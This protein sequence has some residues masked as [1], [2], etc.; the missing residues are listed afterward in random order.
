[1]R[2]LWF[3]KDSPHLTSAYSKIADELVLKRLS[4]HHH[5]AL[6]CT[7]GYDFGC[8]EFGD[9][10]AYPK[11]QD[12][13]GE[14][15]VLDHYRDFG[16][17]LLVTATDVWIFS[18]L[19]QLAQ[20]GQ[21]LWS[22]WCFIDYPVTQQ[23]KA[24][25]SP[26][27]KVVP[28]SRWLEGQLRGIGLENVSDPIFLGVDHE[29]FKP[30]VGDIDSEGKEITKGRLK[31]GLGFPEDSFAILIVAMNQTY[32]K[33]FEEQFHG[34]Q[35]F[36]ENNPDINV[37][38]YCHSIPRVR[39]GFSL[40]ELALEYDLD[41]QRGDITFADTYTIIC[42]GVL[43]YSEDRMAKIY[44]ACDVL[45]ETTTGASP[46]MP[47]LEAQST[48]LPIITTDYCCYPEFTFAGYCAKV[49]KYFRLPSLP[50]IKKALPDPYAIADCLE[51]IL[52]S[53]PDR[54]MKAGVEAM[55]EYTWE[56]TLQGWLRLLKNIELDIETKCLRIPM[57][58]EILQ[59]K[60]SEVM[61]LAS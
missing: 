20:Q 15:V 13:Y 16:A 31:A 6:F 60:A 52:N 34:I 18:R 10:V 12:E 50:W 58:S 38:V 30:W 22:P 27:L 19:P 42:K 9:V 61:I 56:N 44:N 4:K 5:T 3:S 46:G 25:L 26:A 40:P 49:L 48:G 17:D 28:T 24:K 33:A 14:D 7:V 23:E 8:V 36:R 43:G 2:V 57:P 29:I 1:M 59:K 41:Y 54:M 55:K 53:D 39:D 45:L 47:V 37:K 21:L 11:L 51:K 32:R 35:I